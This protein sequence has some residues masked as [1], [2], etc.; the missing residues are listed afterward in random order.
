LY[1]SQN[2]YLR[3]DLLDGGLLEDLNLVGPDLVGL[4]QNVDALVDLAEVRGRAS[5]S[6]LSADS[7][8]SPVV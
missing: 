3:E 5:T 8:S 1:F 6:G 2:D 4:S 7:L